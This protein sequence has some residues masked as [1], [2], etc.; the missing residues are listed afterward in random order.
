MRQNEQA[1]KNIEN[2]MSPNQIGRHDHK[3]ENTKDLEVED[4]EVNVEKIN[5]EEGKDKD[6]PLKLL[7]LLNTPTISSSSPC[8]EKPAS[9]DKT[10]KNDEIVVA[11]D[12]NITVPS[13]ALERRTPQAWKGISLRSSTLRVSPE[14]LKNQSSEIIASIHSA[15]YDGESE[16]LKELLCAKQDISSISKLNGS[17]IP[18]HRAIT[19][20]S[21]HGEAE[22]VEKCMEVLL[23]NGFNLKIY[24]N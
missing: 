18:I 19:G 3:N 17:L 21:Y 7:S 10:M 22:R 24:L 8:Q 6:S 20:L 15:A 9:S 23:K 2:K 11:N 5:E 14:D 1:I 12:F 13:V 16:E 4:I